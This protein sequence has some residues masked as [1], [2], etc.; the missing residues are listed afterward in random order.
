MPVATPSRGSPPANGQSL[1]G[2]GSRR[3][4]AAGHGPP[5]PRLQSA[6]L[7]HRTDP[8]GGLSMAIDTFVTFDGVYANLEDAKADYEALKD[9]HTEADLLDA[10]DAAVI[11]R[12]EDGKVKI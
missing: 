9:L 8:S 5:G 11:E 1:A 3:R 7:P 12:H 10:Y 2:G 6:T 4:P